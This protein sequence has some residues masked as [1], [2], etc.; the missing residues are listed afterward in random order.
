M[1]LLAGGEGGGAQ[2]QVSARW[3]R[4][5]EHT[6]G[7]GALRARAGRTMGLRG[8]AREERERALGGGWGRLGRAEAMASEAPRAQKAMA[9]G[10]EIGGGVSRSQHGGAGG[11]AARRRWSCSP[12]AKA[13]GRRGR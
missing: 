9:A 3:L 11:E 8:L 10:E 13:A 1:E 6:G 2:R 7:G 12:A 5:L 4:V